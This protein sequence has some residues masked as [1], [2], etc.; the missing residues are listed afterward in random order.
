ME[1]TQAERELADA[2]ARVDAIMAQ[3]ESGIEWMDI[4]GLS[5]AEGQ[6]DNA[7]N[8]E[9]AFA[10]MEN[11]RDTLGVRVTAEAESR[12][13][14]AESRAALRTARENAPT[15]N[16]GGGVGGVATATRPAPA[17]T[18]DA[19]SI[20]HWWD[21]GGG[22]ARAPVVPPSTRGT[23]GGVPTGESPVIHAMTAEALKPTIFEYALRET[24]GNLMRTQQMR[25]TFGANAPK[26]GDRLGLDIP[27]AA[28]N[29][30][31]LQTRTIQLGS[32]FTNANLQL[33]P[34]P[35]EGDDPIHFSDLVPM[36]GTS[37]TGIQ[38]N[39]VTAQ[40]SNANP[41]QNVGQDANDATPTTVP[42]TA[43]ISRLPLVLQI[44]ERLVMAPDS[45][46]VMLAQQELTSQMGRLVSGEM[47]NGDGNS[48]N[49]LGIKNRASTHNVT[50][51]RATSDAEQDSGK[52]PFNTF[53]KAVA[54]G[55]GLRAARGFIGGTVAVEPQFLY[56]LMNYRE[57]GEYVF[58]DNMWPLM[59]YGLVW[60]PAYG[61]EAQGTT[62]NLVA[63][64]IS[65]ANNARHWVQ[66]MTMRVLDQTRAKQG[67]IEL[68]LNCYSMYQWVNGGDIV[69]ITEAN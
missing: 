46:T 45:G 68:L 63:V 54:V 55:A 40:P 59:K 2:I 14:N 7:E 30:N 43:E 33:P 11:H 4:E 53:I 18:F 67:E 62:G 20:D 35:F 36:V 50:F 6:E 66:G 19:P 47:I 38:W 65:F 49:Q 42:R 32:D 9:S 12:R 61:L 39:E 64:I 24:E 60:R 69:E 1:M 58:R 21:D 15:A 41:R 51:S 52:A 5:V 22:E 37:Q 25:S 16:S 28:I 10:A 3:R 48:P 27:I 23:V 56:E 34:T 8:R 57:Q 31:S 17:S 26:S 13:R 29:I 44:D